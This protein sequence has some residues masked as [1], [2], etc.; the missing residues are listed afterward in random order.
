MN[1]KKLEQKMQAVRDSK[2]DIRIDRELD[3]SVRYKHMFN[4][5]T[6]PN[7]YAHNT[8]QYCSH[9]R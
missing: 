7:P 1:Q 3:K 4:A 9:S 6:Q 8:P 5:D 2:R